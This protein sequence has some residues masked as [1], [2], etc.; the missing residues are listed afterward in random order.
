MPIPFQGDKS[1]FPAAQEACDR[2]DNDLCIDANGMDREVIIMYLC[3][4]KAVSEEQIREAVE[5]GARTMGDLN[6]RL[7]ISADC[8]KCADSVGAFLDA[9]LATPAPPVMAE[10]APP[11][12]TEAI[13][14]PHKPAEPAPERAWFAVDL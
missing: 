6:I 7:G 4:C 2:R 11:V 3:I 13:K 12:V 14:P 8:G 1:L 9:C 5:L 10:F